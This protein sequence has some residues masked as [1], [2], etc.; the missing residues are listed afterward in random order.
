MAELLLRHGADVNAKDEEGKTPLSGAS[1]FEVFELLL[2]HGADPNVQDNYGA[3]PLLLA[4][5]Y[6]N[7]KI[8]VP[9]L[10]LAHGALV[11][12]PKWKSDGRTAMHFACIHGNWEVAQ[13]LMDSQAD[14]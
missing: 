8:S 10:L 1:K 7:V 4:C 6:N 2:S 12:E 14:I 13:L 5:L 9:T 11:N 3:T